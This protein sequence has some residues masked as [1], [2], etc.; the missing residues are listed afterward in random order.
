M[1]RRRTDGGEE[2]EDE[3]AKVEVKVRARWT[4]DPPRPDYCT[5][6]LSI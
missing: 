1:R 6:R 4:I 3:E 5:R 2:W